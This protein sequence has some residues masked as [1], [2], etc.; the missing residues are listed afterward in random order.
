VH[1]I[2]LLTD[3]VPLHLFEQLFRLRERHPELFDAFTVLVEDGDLLGWCFL[4]VVDHHDEL[5]LEFHHALLANAHG[6]AWFP[7]CGILRLCRS[8]AAGRSPTG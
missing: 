4:A 3:D 7:G 1:R 5:Q 8:K 6:G 2:H